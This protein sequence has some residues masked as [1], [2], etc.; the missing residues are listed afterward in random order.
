MKNYLPIPNDIFEIVLEF[1]GRYDKS[2]LLPS[3]QIIDCRIDKMSFLDKWKGRMDQET[4]EYYYNKIQKIYWNQEHCWQQRTTFCL[5]TTSYINECQRMA[6][7]YTKQCNG[8]TGYIRDKTPNKKL[9]ADD[10]RFSNALCCFTLSKCRE[11]RIKDANGILW[12]SQ[13]IYGVS[14]GTSY[15]EY[16]IHMNDYRVNIYKTYDTKEWNYTVKGEKNGIEIL[17]PKFIQKARK[18]HRGKLLIKQM[19][20]L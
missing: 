15:C 4:F 2:R 11:K 13:K 16:S 3:L 1:D 5:Q 6:N 17:D 12:K 18:T 10:K 9:S 20:K 19:M 7:K 14:V 8:I